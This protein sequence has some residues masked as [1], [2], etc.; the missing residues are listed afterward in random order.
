MKR[1][2]LAAALLTI[3]A[4][5]FAQ[6]VKVN[7][8]VDRSLKSIKA[9]DIKK[10]ITY[11]ADD[12]LKGRLPGT[13]GYK[14]AGDY[15]IEQLK[16]AHIEPAGE[17]GT[18]LQH[19][20][21]RKATVTGSSF[22]VLRNNKSE[23][24]V[25][26]KDYTIS[27][28]LAA[29]STSLEAPVVFAGYGITAP[30]LKYDDYAGVD[31]KGKIVLITRGA[32]AAFP[33][34]VALSYINAKIILANALAH[35]AAGV[36]IASADTLR[37]RAGSSNSTLFPNGKVASSGSYLAGIKL[38][39]TISNARL[40]QL[41]Q[42]D[43]IDTA[44]VLPQIKKGVPASKVLTAQIKV[45]YTS[46]YKDAKT[47]NVIGKVTGSDA[48]LKNEYVIHTAHLD[49]IGIG[50]PIEGDSIYNGAHDNAS[51]SASLIQ[52]AKLYANLQQ[53]PR[54]SALFTFVT[55]EEMGLLGSAYF[56]KAPTVPLSSIVADINSDM[57]T[58]IAP[59]LSAVAIGSE[60]STLAGQVKQAGDYLNIDIEDDPEPEQN[61]FTR[62]DQ[63]SFV[64]AGIP[65]I[66]VKYGNKTSD[67][68]HNLDATVKVWRAKY[69]HKPQDDINGVFD[70]NAGVAYSQFNFLI[71]YLVAQNST[72]P[73]W[74]SDSA[75]N[76]T[77]KP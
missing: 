73:Q 13:E 41:L 42:P 76:K 9:D 28:D 27:P 25:T 77:T 62:S 67:G 74:N 18:Y 36:V 39:G 47:F 7:A 44:V 35:G 4:A 1:T 71:G 40:Q 12:K 20:T 3:P 5:V 50:K 14:L 22:Q 68:K 60:H 24:Y 34:T 45:S 70:F 66:Y 23:D 33:K 6:N 56:A 8:D 31:V 53:K 32:P 75:F 48:K 72:R 30:A 38:F 37:G 2:I 10:D 11:L 26:G 17:N 15:V 16:A 49:H 19:I 29:T 21:L 61:R 52:I 65:S 69:Y 46:S 63:F 64:S 43:G 55:G 57:P 59:F 54:R 58:I 51:G